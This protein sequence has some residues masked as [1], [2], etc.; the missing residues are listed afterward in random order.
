MWAIIAFVAGV[1]LGG[2]LTVF[3]LRPKA[4]GYLRVDNSDPDDNPYLFLELSEHIPN[5]CAKKY[6]TF[7]VKVENFI[8]HE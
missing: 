3:M 6:V 8:P 7:K 2:V 4:I 5:L 1:I